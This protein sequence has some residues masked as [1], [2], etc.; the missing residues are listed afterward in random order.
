MRGSRWFT[1]SGGVAAAL[2][3]GC[4]DYGIQDP[5]GVVVDPVEVEELLVQSAVPGLDVLFVVDS[6]G[7]MRE[8]QRSLAEAAEVFL[9]ALEALDVAYQIGVA[10]TDPADAGVLTGRPWII[11]AAEEDPAA[12]LARALAVG[13]ES[14][15]PAAGLDMA[16]LAL[17]DATGLNTGFRRKDAAL[18]VVF[19]SDGD[20]ASGAR[21]GEDPQGA[22]LAF[23][24]AETSRA[25]RASAVVGDVPAGCDGPGGSALPGTRYA[26]VAEATGG[27]V[28]SVCAADLAVVAASIGDVGVEW[29][30]VFPLQAAPVPG[31]VR[32]EL[33]GVRAETGWQVDPSAPALVFDVAPA[34]GTA[35]RVV[36]TLEDAS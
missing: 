19:L 30:T 10:T 22:F 33:D 15:P 9:A 21:L 7:S 34:P 26:A 2:L 28:V 1:R 25:A 6:T 23:L 24:A 27:V 11:T 14:A 3:A 4:V 13:T 35:I 18:H 31:S 20:D 36:Y 12:A 5:D 29:L 32:V 16:V 8:E 17:E